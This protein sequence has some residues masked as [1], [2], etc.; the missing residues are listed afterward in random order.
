MCDEYR[1]TRN[2]DMREAR[3]IYP[4]NYKVV[5]DPNGNNWYAFATLCDWGNG[6]FLFDALGPFEL[7]E[8]AEIAAIQRCRRLCKGEL[9]AL[10]AEYKPA[11]VRM[12]VLSF[13]PEEF[14]RQFGV[15]AGDS[16]GD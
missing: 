9:S 4:P 12:P 3:V 7:Q 2:A 5:L 11:D 6:E 8:L 13:S 14:E 15:S 16:E 10:L 1:R